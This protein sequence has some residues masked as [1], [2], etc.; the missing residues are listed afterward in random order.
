MPETSTTARDKLLEVEAILQHLIKTQAAS[1]ENADVIVPAL[2]ESAKRRLQDA[3]S[4][5]PQ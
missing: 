4:K 5:L 2:A 1:D 3:I